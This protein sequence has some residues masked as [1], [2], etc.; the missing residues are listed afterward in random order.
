M[1][2]QPG[3]WQ[4][5]QA[6]HFHCFARAVT[7]PT[8]CAA[9]APYDAYGGD[10]SVKGSHRELRHDHLVQHDIVATYVIH[11]RPAPNVMAP[12][13]KR[14]LRDP[15]GVC[16][17]QDRKGLIRVSW[18]IR[19]ILS[20]FSLTVACSVPIATPAV[21]SYGTKST[22][23]GH[24][25]PNRGKEH[26]VVHDHVAARKGRQEGAHGPPDEL[27]MRAASFCLAMCSAP[28]LCTLQHRPSQTV[29]DYV[30]CSAARCC[31][32][33]WKSGGSFRESSIVRGGGGVERNGG[34]T[35][36]AAGVLQ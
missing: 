14:G 6:D 8:S 19:V 15:Q 10:D 4:R 3:K 20:T 13:L 32:P 2:E 36:V 11:T 30:C 28:S 12:W 27:R 18:H 26:A 34:K 25:S 23:M 17:D 29:S 5:R 33:D 21:H 35:L 9:A 1:A 16:D 22:S 7:F 24:V 31:T